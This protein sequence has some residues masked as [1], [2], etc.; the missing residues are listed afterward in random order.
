MP[1][2]PEVETLRRSLAPAL[3]GAR[4]DA[5]AA[6]REDLR[7]PI[8]V[9]D[10][11]ARLP[12]STCL[13]IERRSKVLIF[14]FG[15]THAE[16]LLLVHLGMS[17][18][19]LISKANTA[20]ERHEHLRI[21]F[22]ENVL[23]YIDPRRFGSVELCAPQERSTHPR[24]KGLGPEPWSADF[25]AER[26]YAATRGRSLALRDLF[27]QGK[28]VCG[29][30]NIY[31]NETCFRA[32]LRPQRAA[33]GLTR[34]QAARLVALAREVLEE[35]ISA[36]G[37]TLSDGGYVDAEGQSGWFQTRL[38]VYGRE[39]QPCLQ[40]QSPIQKVEAMSRSAFFCP[41]CQR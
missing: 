35:A 19:L 18:R 41:R 14:H 15:A 40:C 20:L 32:G 38:F 4:C 30:G 34:P 9:A 13:S 33:G 29:L 21:H 12:G 8:P 3:E 17:G 11:A 27:L 36:G 28:V 22:G 1:E 7:F 25:N 26:L 10:L 37:S 16:S 5:F 6:F 24:L 31:A 23:R 2:L 39:G